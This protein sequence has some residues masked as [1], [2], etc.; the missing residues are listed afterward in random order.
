MSEHERSGA[1]GRIRWAVLGTANIARWNFLPSLELAGG[2]V[3]A[4]G[5]R[6]PDAA[7]EF[8]VAN[9]LAAEPCSYLEALTRNDVEAVYVALPNHL[10]LPW[11]RAALEHGKAV[12]CEKPL[13]CTPEEVEE[14][15]AVARRSGRPLFEAFAFP[16]HGQF[17][18]LTEMLAGGGIGELREIQSNFHFQVRDPSNIRWDPAMAGGS[19]NDVGCYPIHLGRLLFGAEPVAASA[20][21]SLGGKGVDAECQAVV[22]FDRGRRLLFSSGLQRRRDTA[23]RLLGTRGEIHLSDPFHPSAVDSVTV[24]RDREEVHHLVPDEPSFAAMLRSINSALSGRS[25]AEHLALD[26]ALG[27]ARALQMVRSNWAVWS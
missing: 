3:V 6:H 24:T 27:T 17:Q 14:L 15:L 21:V 7:R 4:V 11:S 9:R 19:L 26:E 18:F 5:S 2:V 8:I 23:T 16:F 25:A 13:G 12:L 10:H 20:V 22:D 1:N